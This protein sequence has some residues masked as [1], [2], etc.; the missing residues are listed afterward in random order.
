MEVPR[1]SARY[2]RWKSVIVVSLYFGGLSSDNSSFMG[3]YSF[4]FGKE[5]VEKK[6]AT[7]ILGPSFFASTL[8]AT[9]MNLSFV[10]NCNPK[11][12]PIKTP[13]KLFRRH[14]PHVGCNFVLLNGYMLLKM[15]KSSNL[16]MHHECKCEHSLVIIDTYVRL[17][18]EIQGSNL[19]ASKCC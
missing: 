11:Q 9:L 3:P 6:L 2:W 8:C 12:H 10:I 15:P 16:H 17:K 14:R 7:E 19:P 13:S 1:P 5:S 18:Q 4:E